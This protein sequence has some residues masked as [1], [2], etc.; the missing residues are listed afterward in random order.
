MST[1]YA[2]RKKAR[3]QTGR[4][5][6]GRGGRNLPP[7][8][9]DCL[10]CHAFVALEYSRSG[11]HN[12]NHCPYCLWSRHLDLQSPGDR[13]SACKAGMQPVG[14]TLK[15]TRKKYGPGQG[16]LMLIH[17]C[18]DCGSISINRIAADD[19]PHRVFGVFEFPP[20]PEAWMAGRL[21]E[22]GITAINAGDAEIVRL[23]LFGG[24]PG[25]E[26]HPTAWLE[27][28]PGLDR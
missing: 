10:H 11:V 7:D 18:A 8:G 9:F 3:S 2:V 4:H 15:K 27:D 12:R 21:A 23:Q 19:D 16:E 28:R 14:L 22:A 20:E 26:A 17:V 1:R 24:H 5:H 25:L 6:F 13:L